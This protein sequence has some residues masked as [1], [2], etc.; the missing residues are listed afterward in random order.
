[1][2]FKVLYQLLFLLLFSVVCIAQT[3]TKDRFVASNGMI[4][5]TETIEVK[6]MD[7]PVIVATMTENL[8]NKKYIRLDSSQEEGVLS[9][10]INSS[11]IPKLSS[12]RFRID[13]LYESYIVTISEIEFNGKQIE[14]LLLKNRGRFVEKIPAE[15]EVFD[16]E[17]ILLFSIDF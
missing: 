11:F 3:F 1:M 10:T 2:L 12:A 8:T 7:T 16:S 5:W 4:V 14:P 17:M 6:D 9:G 15:I 13:F